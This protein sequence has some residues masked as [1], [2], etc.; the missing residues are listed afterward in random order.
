VRHAMYQVA[1]M[2]SASEY[3][4]RD[5][6][7][8]RSSFA[9]YEHQRQAQFHGPIPPPVALVGYD[10]TGKPRMRQLTRMPSLLT[11]VTMG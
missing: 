11:I 5:P 2:D 1:T 9:E 8:T 4:N 10:Q 7:N 6:P 3:Q